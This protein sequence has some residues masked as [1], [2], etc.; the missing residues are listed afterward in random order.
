MR[1]DCVMIVKWLCRYC[2]V[3]VLAKCDQIARKV[4]VDLEDAEAAIDGAIK[5]PVEGSHSNG[6]EWGGGGGGGGA[7]GGGKRGYTF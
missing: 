5:R 7:G 1:G 3:I 6:G 4:M 2:V